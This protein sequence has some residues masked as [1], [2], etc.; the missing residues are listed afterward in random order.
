[1][2]SILP[3]VLGPVQTNAY[4][5]A[6]TDTRLAIVVDPAWDG[7]VILQAAAQHGWRIGGLWL[8]HAHFDHIG[9][10]GEVADGSSPM[11]A[12]ALHPDD[13]PLWRAQGGAPFFGMRID[14]GPEP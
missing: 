8:T 12:V 4:L 2:L 10:A 1:M 13:Y 14:P 3:F 7:Q 6:D 5:A 11:P 9:G